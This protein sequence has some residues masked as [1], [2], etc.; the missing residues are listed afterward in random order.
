MNLIAFTGSLE[1]GKST[2]AAAL[3]A[4]L[5][6]KYQTRCLAFA[7]PMK[8]IAEEYFHFS[9]Y[10]LH[11][12]EGKKAVHP[13]WNITAREF[14]QKFGQG[15]REL[16]CPDVWVKI[17]EQI[18]EDYEEKER[19]HKTDV[20]LLIIDDLRMDNEAEMIK[21]HNGTIV[22]ISRPSHKPISAGIIGHASEQGIDKKYI[23]Y[24]VCNNSTAES[25]YKKI[26]KLSLELGY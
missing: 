12:P 19:Q 14:L 26:E 24:T 15:M 1:A 5:Y 25:L 8:K 6:Y 21:R 13:V 7:G 18:I 23:D 4:I 11:T 17:T 10:M 2:A 16:I 3:Q 22:E 20:K 9:E